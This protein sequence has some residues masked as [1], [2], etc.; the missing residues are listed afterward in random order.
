MSVLYLYI[1]LTV[2]NI[3]K[4]FCYVVFPEVRLVHSHTCCIFVL[5]LREIFYLL[6]LQ[7][8]LLPVVKYIIST[9]LLNLKVNVISLHLMSYH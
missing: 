7:T 5:F 9:E 3:T 4:M 8:P 6:Q 1:L 2:Y